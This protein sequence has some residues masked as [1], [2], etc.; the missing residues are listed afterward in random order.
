MPVQPQ[1]IL[2]DMMKNMWGDLF[3]G[4]CD[5]MFLRHL[6]SG[7]SQTVQAHSDCPAYSP[8]GDHSCS[9][10]HEYNH[11]V[12][13]CAPAD[14]EDEHDGHDHDDDTTTQED[15]EGKP[16]TTSGSTSLTLTMGSALGIATLAM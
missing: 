12:H 3:T 15:G 16:T 10:I 9:E 8:S 4:P 5:S 7:Q 14:D 11:E 6:H 1:Q 13:A 2:S